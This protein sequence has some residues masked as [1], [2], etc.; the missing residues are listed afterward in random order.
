MDPA[1]GEGLVQ[2]RRSLPE[3]E[4][5]QRGRDGLEGEE[6]EGAEDQE[7]EGP[8][9]KDSSDQREDVEKGP[10]GDD[11][12]DG[13]VE[14]QDDSV[15][16]EDRTTLDQE[17]EKQGGENHHL[18]LL[19]VQEGEEDSR[20]EEGDKEGSQGLPEIDNVA[21]VGCRRFVVEGELLKVEEGVLPCRLKAGHRMG[22]PVGGPSQEA[23]EAVEWG[24]EEEP[25]RLSGRQPPTRH[26]EKE[27][28][29]EGFDGTVVLTGHGDSR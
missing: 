28:D 27:G 7:G 6:E 18:L 24:E 22:D 17:V 26:Q 11:Q 10:L 15:P 19:A 21:E 20:R 29:Q 25:Q 2:G 23:Q 12:G 3:V 13:S 8:S 16:V 4:E 1:E 5:G 9:P 14:G